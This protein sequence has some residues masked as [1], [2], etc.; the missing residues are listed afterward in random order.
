MKKL[1]ISDPAPTQ[2]QV[3]L[4]TFRGNVSQLAVIY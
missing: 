4:I 1:Y 3:Y 2:Y